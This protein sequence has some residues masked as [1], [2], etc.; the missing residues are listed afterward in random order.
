MS[1]MSQPDVNTE[2]E[3]GQKP[4]ILVIDDS[5]E[6]LQIVRRTLQKADFA[7]WTAISGEQ[8]LQIINMS[9]LPDLAIVDLNMPP[10]MDGFEFSERL[11][12]FCDLPLIM[13]TAVDEARTVVKA[14]QQFAE[15]Y[16]IKPFNPAELVA[17]VRRVLNRVGEFPYAAASPIIV[18]VQMTVDF[19]G[20]KIITADGA[21]CSLT[22]TESRLLYILMRSSGETVA[23]DFLLRRM[24]PREVTYEDR[25]HVYVHRLRSKLKPIS[26]SHQYVVSERGEGYRFQ[27][28]Q[29]A[30]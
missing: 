23:T 22:P 1:V 2:I 17:R 27:P 13:L 24:W 9:G 12:Q 19:P 26:G 25:L 5:P 15:D 8:A 3:Q 4:C 21:T 7:V 14:I 11:L 30:G 10:G 18:D 6:T 16:I 28:R 20:R 29:E